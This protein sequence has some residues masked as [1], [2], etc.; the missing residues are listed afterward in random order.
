M[1]AR[2]VLSKGI[3]AI[4]DPGIQEENRVYQ[5]AYNRGQLPIRV[6]TYDGIWRNESPDEMAARFRTFGLNSLGDDTV[7]AVHEDRNG[8]LW[9]ATTGGLG[10]FDPATGEFTHL[11]EKD[12]LP[13]DTLYGILEDG[14]GRLWISTNNG[15][16]RYD[17]SEDTFV[18][19]DVRDGLQSNEFNMNSFLKTREGEMLFGGINGLNAFYPEEVV[20]NPYIPPVVITDFQ[21]FNQS[22]EPGEESLLESSISETDEI[23]LSFKD[24]FFSFEPM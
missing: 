14:E 23:V 3:V 19:Y 24:D 11:T 16:A 8:I 5:E 6:T 21:L 13:N 10:R 2:T 15:I 4:V 22:V 7:L 1:G 12:G 9:I 20:D 17:P 18:N